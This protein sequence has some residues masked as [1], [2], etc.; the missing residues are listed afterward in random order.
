MKKKV[1]IFFMSLIFVSALSGNLFAWAFDASYP[2]KY[3]NYVTH[4]II[5]GQPIKYHIKD[6]TIK[7]YPISQKMY[8]SKQYFGEKPQISKDLSQQLT[9]EEREIKVKEAFEKGFKLWFDDTRKAIANAGRSSEF[10]DIKSQLSP[11]ISFTKVSEPK[12]AD[13]IIEI[14]DDPKNTDNW[15][16]ENNIITIHGFPIKR[17]AR[18]VQFFLGLVPE[19]SN[20]SS[21]PFSCYT[22]VPTF[23]KDHLTCA[24]VDGLINLIDFTLSKTKGW[25]DRAQNGWTSFCA[26]KKDQNNKPY[27]QFKYKKAQPESINKTR[28]KCLYAFEEGKIE[29]VRCLDPFNFY[30]TQKTFTEGGLVKTMDY[31]RDHFTYD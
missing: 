10:S 26:G 23:S 3:K 12:Q 16:K 2:E 15:E 6:D 9:A 17:S 4:K 27:L 18:L 14:K 22:N 1:F 31:G 24:S 28:G 8:K 29:D 25:S 7:H 13:I 21:V 5:N 19:D 30:K 20:K 11:A